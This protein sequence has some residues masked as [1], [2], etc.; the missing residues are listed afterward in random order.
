M[1]GSYFMSAPASNIAD[2]RTLAPE[3]K[4]LMNDFTRYNFSDDYFNYHYNGGCW[5][6]VF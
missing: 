1:G 2:F 6:L 5:E 3:S 4:L